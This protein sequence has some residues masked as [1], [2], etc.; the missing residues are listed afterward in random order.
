MFDDDDDD[1]DGI[2]ALGSLVLLWFKTIL[3]PV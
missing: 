3:L 2:K 1:D